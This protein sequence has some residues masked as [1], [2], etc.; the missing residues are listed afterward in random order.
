M[1]TSNI[2]KLT[3]DELVAIAALV[4]NGGSLMVVEPL[5]SDEVT[6]LEKLLEVTDNCLNGTIKSPLFD[7]IDYDNL[8][9]FYAWADKETKTIVDGYN[10]EGDD[11]SLEIVG[12]RENKTFKSLN[13]HEGE[14]Y[15]KELE[16]TFT[17]EDG[18][19]TTTP[20]TLSM[21][22]KS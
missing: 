1:H 15:K 3:K 18:T 5:P 12:W 17:N 7:D 11:N 14:T 8:E 13:V 10:I 6:L 2:R 22:M 20:A 9:N 21:R 4:V 19:E 16:V